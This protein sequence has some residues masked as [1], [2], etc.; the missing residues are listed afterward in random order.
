MKAFNGQLVATIKTS[1]KTGKI[2]FQ[3]SCKDLKGATN[4]TIK[5]ISIPV[6]SDK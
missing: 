4:K 6:D 3:A 1:K 2:I 5:L